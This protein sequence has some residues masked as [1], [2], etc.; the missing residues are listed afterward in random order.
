M[1]L[2]DRARKAF[3][4]LAHGAASGGRLIQIQAELAQLENQIEIQQREAGKIAQQLWRQGAFQDTEF[5]SVMRR[6]QELQKQV[7]ELRAEYVKVEAEGVERPGPL[8]CAKCGR[9]LDQ[10]DRFCRGCGTPLPPPS[11]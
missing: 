5:D 1:D 3:D 2:F 10:E 4:D 11:A 9:E 6:L 7:E 8:R